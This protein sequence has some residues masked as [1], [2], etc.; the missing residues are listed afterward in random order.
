MP[1]LTPQIPQIE[2][3]PLKV[4]LPAGQASEL[5]VLARITPAPVP[6]QT[7][8]RPPL[9]LALVIDRSN[10]LLW[11]EG[12]GQPKQLR[13]EQTLGNQLTVKLVVYGYAA[14]TSGRYPQAVAQVGG[15]DA[16]AGQGQIAPTF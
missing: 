5:T 7:G 16:T 9:N 11:E 13:F 1:D 3:L 12:D 2:L 4:G 15:F 14:F 10:C 8:A 6:Q